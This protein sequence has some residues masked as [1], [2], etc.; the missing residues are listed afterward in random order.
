M[1]GRVCTVC[2]P[3]SYPWPMEIDYQLSRFGAN[4]AEVAR[5][6]GLSEQAARRHLN[7]GHGQAPEKQSEVKVRHSAVK[8]RR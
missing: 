1:S 8:V 5:K 3:T 7:A 2:Y 4:V 6:Y